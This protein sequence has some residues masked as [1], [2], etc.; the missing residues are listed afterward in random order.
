[1]DSNKDSKEDEDNL[2]GGHQA[3]YYSAA[4]S[5]IKG[6]E[7]AEHGREAFSIAANVDMTAVELWDIISDKPITRSCLVAHLQPPTAMSSTTETVSLS[8]K[9]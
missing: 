1:L 7:I 8:Y 5:D 9:V 4:N 2:E 3:S 6:I